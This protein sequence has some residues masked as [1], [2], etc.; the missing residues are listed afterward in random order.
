MPFQLNPAQKKLYSIYMKARRENKL[1]RFIVLK[2]RREGVSTM[3]EGLIYQR[4]KNQFN[5]RAAIVAHEIDACNVL[6]DMF[7]TFNEHDDAQAEIEHSNE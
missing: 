7:K 3:V 1:L 2:A 4:T 6:F 5:R